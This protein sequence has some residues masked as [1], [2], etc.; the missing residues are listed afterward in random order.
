MLLSATKF[1]AEPARDIVKF[2]SSDKYGGI[3]YLGASQLRKY[4]ESFRKFPIVYSHSLL[5]NLSSFRQGP[6]MNIIC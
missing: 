6:L 3:H 1:L 2:K 4:M 5:K